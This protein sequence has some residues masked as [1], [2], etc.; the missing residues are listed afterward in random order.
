MPNLLNN[1]WPLLADHRHEK[2]S[3]DLTKQLTKRDDARNQG[4]RNS[5]AKLFEHA[6]PIEI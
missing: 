3:E 1:D 2:R 4:R 5:E 6:W